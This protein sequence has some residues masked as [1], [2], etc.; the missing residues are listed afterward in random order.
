MSIS[1]EIQNT[2]DISERT[3]GGQV[4]NLR[5]F[6]YADTNG[7][8]KPNTRYSI[9]YTINK[10]EV[11]ITDSNNGRFIEPVDNKSIF[12]EY[13]DLINPIRADYPQPITLKPT[14][15]DYRLGEVKR[16]FTRISNDITKTPFEIDKDTFNNK[17]SLYEYVDTIWV[18]SGLKSEVERYNSIRI[19]FLESKLK[20]ISKILFPLQL[21]TPP[22]DSTEDLENKLRRLKK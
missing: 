10:D 9:Y 3:I 16:Y 5:E 6:R 22:K 14:E 2:K 19:R 21:W 18:I 15:A 17:N 20:G 8:V 4:T 11:Y 1:E 7:F 13:S 12:S